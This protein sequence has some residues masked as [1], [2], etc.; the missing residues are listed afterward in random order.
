MV[1]SRAIASDLYA[2]P[3][4]T[5]VFS[6]LMVVTGIAPI[7]AP[8]AGGQL[9]KISDWNGIFLILGALGILIIFAVILGTKE[10][11]SKEDR[12]KGG[13]KESLT[14]FIKLFG[15]RIFMGYT[16]TQGLIVAGMFGYISASPLVLQD[17]YGL[18]AQQFSFCF[19]INGLGMII[20]SQ[21]T[22]KFTEK[23]GEIK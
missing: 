20:A 21:L 18:S 3:E 13:I 19:A 14:I 2:G 22:G 1:I 7:I 17:I 12:S 16:L 23:Y 9:V 6:L 4:L 15:D 8:V 11:L 10:T 5:K